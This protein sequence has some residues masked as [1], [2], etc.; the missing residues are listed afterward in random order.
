MRR[1]V[2]SPRP[3]DDHFVV[4]EQRAVEEEG[5][6]FGEP[7]LE[8]LR[9]AGAAGRV[10]ELAARRLDG[11][12]DRAFADFVGLDLF[13]LEPQR[14]LAGNREQFERQPRQRLERLAELD[15]AARDDV[16]A[17]DVEDAVRADRVQSGRR[18]PDRERLALAQAQ[19]ARRVIDVGVGQQHCG[20]RRMAP[21]SLRL[22]RRRRQ[23]LLAQIDRGVEQEPVRSVHADR[24]ARLGA[25]LHSPV[26]A[27]GEAADPAAAIPLRHAA[28]GART[29][30]ERSQ[31]R[32]GS[33]SGGHS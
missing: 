18:A 11:D 32:D 2:L 23:N 25:R 26:A 24:E 21:L 20:D 17:D 12:P 27:P 4:G 7:L 19:Q 14:D 8:I 13:L 16:A 30:H 22:E 15:G 33:A 9:H 6:G 31:S 10:D 5:V 1:P 28:A 29:E 3:F